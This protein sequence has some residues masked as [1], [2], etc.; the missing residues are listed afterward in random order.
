M[1]CLWR[2][3]LLWGVHLLQCQVWFCTSIGLGCIEAWRGV[4]WPR[5]TAHYPDSIRESSSCLMLGN[6]AC[7]ALQAWWWNVALRAQI[8]RWIG[9]CWRMGKTRTRNTKAGCA[10][11]ASACNCYQWISPALYWGSSC[12]WA[13]GPLALEWYWWRNAFSFTGQLRFFWGSHELCSSPQFNHF[14]RYSTLPLLTCQSSIS[15]TS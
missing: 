7:F 1:Y 14:T 3:Q 9:C 15:S 8:N 4:P 10:G 5:M 11:I 12:P 6:T 13:S 2:V